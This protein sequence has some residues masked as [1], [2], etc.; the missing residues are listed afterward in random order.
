MG[1]WSPWGQV[2][3]P[4][5]E[6]ELSLD[7]K[8]RRPQVLEPVAAPAPVAEDL[9]LPSR[10][11]PD[12]HRVAVA[13]IPPV[14]PVFKI[15]LG[16]GMGLHPQ[17]FPRELLKSSESRVISGAAGYGGL[18]PSASEPALLP[19]QHYDDGLTS[20]ADPVRRLW[21]AGAPAPAEEPPVEPIPEP[22]ALKGSAADKPVGT[23]RR[24]RHAKEEPEPPPPPTE[25]ERRL[26]RLPLGKRFHVEFKEVQREGRLR[27]QEALAERQRL[28]DSVFA[29]KHAHVKLDP[30][31][32][33]KRAMAA[34]D[35]SI[36]GSGAG[37]STLSGF[38]GNGRSSLAVSSSVPDLTKAP[39][40]SSHLHLDVGSGGPGRRQLSFNLPANPSTASQ[41]TQS[42]PPVGGGKASV[43]SLEGASHPLGK[44]GQPTF[45]HEATA[46]IS[47]WDGGTLRLWQALQ[48]AAAKP[49][50]LPPFMSPE[51]ATGLVD[52]LF[53]ALRARIEVGPVSVGLDLLTDLFRATS[54]PM[55]EVPGARE[56]LLPLLRIAAEQASAGAAETRRLCHTYAFPPEEAVSPKRPAGRTQNISNTSSP[57][58][59]FRGTSS[60]ASPT[61]P[62]PS[63]IVKPRAILDGS[64]GDDSDAELDALFD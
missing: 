50:P 54:K 27:L 7:R 10:P 36:G 48:E 30:L 28:R 29:L 5:G 11:A 55:M 31:V 56:V 2:F 47:E 21:M 35:R 60:V 61:S 49:R 22:K 57:D 46:H 53:D 4:H 43:A 37:S 59:S 33:E 15:G 63:K 41:P 52:H 24:S 62:P 17:R 9:E 34:H 25:L 13:N 32:V 23:T 42:A 38:G 14:P 3:H 26:G 51:D 8:P 58:F 6:V 19:R 16:L 1:V 40:S 20:A 64:I 12:P 18:N 45:W 44:L 39:S